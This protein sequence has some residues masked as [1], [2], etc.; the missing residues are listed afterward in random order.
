[1]KLNE[2]IQFLNREHWSE[3]NTMWNN[4]NDEFSGRQTMFCLCW[5][6]ATWLHESNC[7][8]FRAKVNSETVKRLQHLI[9]KK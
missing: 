4:V 7:T 6:L 9:P 8:R 5:R 3:F 1:M 2:K